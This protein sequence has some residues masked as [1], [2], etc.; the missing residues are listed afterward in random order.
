MSKQTSEKKQSSKPAVKKDG[1]GRPVTKPE[2]KAPEAE[3]PAKKEAKKEGK[4]VASKVVAAAT[5]K[6]KAEPKEK[7]ENGRKG[8]PLGN[9]DAEVIAKVKAFRKAGNTSFW[10][11]VKHLRK[12][13]QM[14]CS[15]DRLKRL[16][17]EQGWEY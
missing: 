13:L 3:A 16:F 10:A 6:V 17:T 8:V 5:K 2:K 1:L 9:S 15:H 11:A 7:K 12:E 14:R 4:A